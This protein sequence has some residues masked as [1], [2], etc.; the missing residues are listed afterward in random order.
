MNLT[1]QITENPTAEENEWQCTALGQDVC[2]VPKE[3]VKPKTTFFA[4]KFLNILSC[5]CLLQRKMLLPASS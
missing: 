3:R 5:S 2:I 4:S 1:D